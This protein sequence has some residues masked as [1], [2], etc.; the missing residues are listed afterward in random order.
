MKTDFS[1]ASTFFLTL[2]Q[3]FF[4]YVFYLEWM[5]TYLNHLTI[6]HTPMLHVVDSRCQTSTGWLTSRWALRNSTEPLARVPRAIRSLLTTELRN[7]GGSVYGYLTSDSFDG[8][9]F[10]HGSRQ[11]FSFHSFCSVAFDWSADSTVINSDKRKNDVLKYWFKV[12][13]FD[14]FKR[15]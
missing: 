4:F 11:S 3:H 9:S 14:P 8:R 6:L 15:A 7:C 1:P 10:R 5:K 2:Y 13:K 12:E